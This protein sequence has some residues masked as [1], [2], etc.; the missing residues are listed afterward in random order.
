[1]ATQNQALILRD[2]EG[3]LYAIPQA[4]LEAARVPA[5]QQRALQQAL[6]D[7]VSGYI[8]LYIPPQPWPNPVTVLP[9]LPVALPPF[10][11]PYAP[12]PDPRF[13]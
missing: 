5:D 6:D 4:Q 3:N 13:Q 11:S 2:R 10:E 9:Y 12:P 1:M 7:E 8:G